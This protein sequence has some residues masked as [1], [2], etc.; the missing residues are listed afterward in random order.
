MKT[1]SA[2][3]A[4][5]FGLTGLV[6]AQ[7]GGLRPPPTYGMSKLTLNWNE[8]MLTFIKAGITHPPTRIAT[9]FLKHTKMSTLSFAHLHS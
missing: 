9:L 5:I 2:I 6:Q 3:Q 4:A 7:S 8:Y 1:I